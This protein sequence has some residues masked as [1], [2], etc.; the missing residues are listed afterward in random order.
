MKKK[1]FPYSSNMILQ[2]EIKS[3]GLNISFLTIDEYVQI[4]KDIGEEVPLAFAKK[5]LAKYSDCEIEIKEVFIVKIISFIEKNYSDKNKGEI[6]E[7][8]DITGARLSKI[9]HRSY[10][11]LSIS[12]LVKILFKL[13][14]KFETSTILK[15]A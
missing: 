15:A 10:S 11:E 9:V 7:L 5:D 2:E 14:R 4:S 8:L 3:R 6:S 1:Y 12:Y 13:D